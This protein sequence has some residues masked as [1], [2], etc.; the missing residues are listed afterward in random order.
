MKTFKQFISE[1][2]KI[3]SA[4]DE[5]RR[6]VAFEREAMGIKDEDVS[7]G[8]TIRD[9][10]RHMNQI[11]YE[12]SKK[13]PEQA[14]QKFEDEDIKDAALDKQNQ[15]I[16]IDNTLNQ[17]IG[18]TPLKTA[19]DIPISWMQSNYSKAIDSASQR[20]QVNPTYK[21]AKTERLNAV[22]KEQETK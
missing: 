9:I 15:L 3:L 1:E 5:A 13:Y 10:G 18:G 19:L 21:Y 16:G 6:R 7:K 22:N 20:L 11:E 8:K 14:L 2:E 17:Y 12:Y 4:A